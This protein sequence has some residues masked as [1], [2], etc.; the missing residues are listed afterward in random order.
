MKVTKKDFIKGENKMNKCPKC[1]QEVESKFC[2]DCGIN[3]QE[4]L[5]CPKCG[6]VMKG[7]FCPDCGHDSQAKEK[8]KVRSEGK[9]YVFRDGDVAL[10]RFNV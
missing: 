8:G 4:P 10:F 1:G 7:R 2:P 5:K 9:E 6:A 3:V